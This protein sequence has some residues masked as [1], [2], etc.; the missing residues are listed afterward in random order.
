ML[1]I[2]MRLDVILFDVGY[3][4]S[5]NHVVRHGNTGAKIMSLGKEQGFTSSFDRFMPRTSTLDELSCHLCG[6]D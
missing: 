5:K 2:F 4:I 3:I 1:L 6:P